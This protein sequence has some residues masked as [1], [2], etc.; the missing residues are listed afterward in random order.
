MRQVKN[1]PGYTPGPMWMNLCP[2]YGLHFQ[3]LAYVEEKTGIPFQF[4]Y[5]AR[6]LTR[7][8]GRRP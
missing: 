7:N 1:V 8:P 6:A 5:K 2:K 3:D 4:M